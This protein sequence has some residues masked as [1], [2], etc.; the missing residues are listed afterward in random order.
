M[1]D[2]LNKQLHTFNVDE[3]AEIRRIADTIFEPLIRPFR[4]RR[5]VENFSNRETIKTAM[6]I[7]HLMPTYVKEAREHRKS[8]L[9]IAMSLSGIDRC[10]AVSLIPLFSTLQQ[11]ALN[12]KLFIYTDDIIQAEFTHDGFLANDWR[13]AWNHVCGPVV[14]NKLQEMSFDDKEDTLLVIDSLGGGD[15]TWYSY[16]STDERDEVRKEQEKYLATAGRYGWAHRIRQELRGEYNKINRIDLP[17][18]WYKLVDRNCSQRWME[19]PAL[20]EYM[21]RYLFN[22][23]Y[24]SVKHAQGFVPYN[25]AFDCMKKLKGKFKNMHLLTPNMEKGNYNFERIKGLNVFDY[26]HKA[27]TVRGF[28]EVLS[29][30]VHGST[31][32]EGQYTKKI[33]YEVVTLGKYVEPEDA[34]DMEQVE[35]DGQ[36]DEEHTEMVEGTGECFVNCPDVDCYMPSVKTVKLDKGNRA[37]KEITKNEV[38]FSMLDI[39][40]YLPTNFNYMSDS[41]YWQNRVIDDFKNDDSDSEYTRLVKAKRVLDQILKYHLVCMNNNV[42]LAGIQRVE[43]PKDYIVKAT[44]LMNK[45]HYEKH[46]TR[47]LKQDVDDLF[48][49]VA[50]T[51]HSYMEALPLENVVWCTVGKYAHQKRSI[52]CQITGT[53]SKKR[54]ITFHETLHWLESICPAVGVFTNQLLRRKCGGIDRKELVSVGDGEKAM[55]VKDGSKEW[56]T[57]YAGKWYSRYHPHLPNNTEI[58]S[59][60]GEYFSSPEKLSVLMRH[61]PFMVRFIAFILM[62][63]PVAAMQSLQNLKQVE[64]LDQ[65]RQKDRKSKNIS[66]RSSR[67]GSRSSSR[68]STFRGK[69][70]SG[71]GL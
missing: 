59:V 63:G 11:T 50:P 51:Y 16:W 68:G 42:G 27:N 8:R 64:A 71:F 26:H 35:S 19:S 58:L 43:R 37:T 23:Q 70:S 10:S 32:F 45:V 9:V 5:V 40:D 54:E 69:K 21:V 22:P 18:A 17:E 38:P 7:G 20:K 6:R 13:L 14:F 12:F 61:D 33:S 31:V 36:G 41:Y 2:V 60:Y 66:S 57:P 46:R 49:M 1:D 4:Q 53:R 44:E 47:M 67:G 25:D 29:T 28:A 39:N 15:S 34:D 30:I 3:L 52:S 62:G 56:I 55:P 24:G 48:T 65:I